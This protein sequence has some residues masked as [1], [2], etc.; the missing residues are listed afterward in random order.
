MDVNRLVQ[1]T[2]AQGARSKWDV[3]DKRMRR[4]RKIR[5]GREP[6]RSRHVSQKKKVKK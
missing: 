4:A 3:W 1:P 5:Q 2:S 6:I